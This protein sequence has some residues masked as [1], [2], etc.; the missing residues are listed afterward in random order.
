MSPT[1]P[2][3]ISLEMLSVHAS[4]F[5][6]SCAPFREGAFVTMVRM[7]T[8]VHV[9]PETAAAVKPRPGANEN[10]GVEPLGAVVTGRSTVIRGDIVI[11]IRALGSNADVHTDLSVRLGRRSRE[12]DSNH[13]G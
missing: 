9:A 5:L 2:H 3:F 13:R 7:K 4:G 11:T 12:T 6:G 10:A 1:V 8:I